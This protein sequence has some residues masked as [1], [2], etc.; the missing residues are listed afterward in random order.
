MV[1]K[2]IHG[3]VRW[4]RDIHLSEEK[5][6]ANQRDVEDAVTWQWQE[7]TPVDRGMSRQSWDS[8]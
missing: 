8:G 2:E 1:T 4:Y 6:L 5:L 7:A 3:Q